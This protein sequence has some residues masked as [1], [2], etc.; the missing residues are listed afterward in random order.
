M[1]EDKTRADDAP[2]PERQPAP[3]PDD[4][5]RDE[6]QTRRQAPDSASPGEASGGES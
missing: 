2:S 6:A 4:I 5:A 3:P 1:S